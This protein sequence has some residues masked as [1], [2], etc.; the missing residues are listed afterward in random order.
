MRKKIV[1]YYNENPLK[2]ILLIAFIVRL[3][4]VLFS[5]GFGMHDDHFLI[6]ES[7]R[8][9]LEGGD[10]NRWLPW[11]QNTDNP[12]P[13]G[14]SLFYPG[15]MYCFLSILKLI[16]I[17]SLNAQMYF[18]R[19]IH[20]LWSLL[21]VYY[22]YKITEKYTN[23][24]TANI[25]GWALALYFF[26]PWLSVR[27]LVEVVA[28]P[29]LMAA[30]WLY[31]KDET[32]K[33]G[34]VLWVGA[35]MGMAMCVRYQVMFFIG[36]FGLALLIMKRWK[37]AIIY[38]IGVVLS[39]SIIQCIP[40][41][42]LW[43][44]PFAEFWEYISYNWINSTS[45]FNQPWYNYILVILGLMLPPISVFIFGGFFYEW[46][47]WVL[48]LPSFA[49]LFFHSVFPN[50]QERF[51]L[52]IF[53]FIIFLG[54]IGIYDYWQ[55][56]KCRFD[57]PEGVETR[58]KR[59]HS[60]Q[61]NKSPLR[62]TFRVCL[63]ISLI[64]NIIALIPTTIHY[65]KKARVEAMVYLSNYPES[66]YYIIEGMLSYGVRMPVEAY[67]DH[68]FKAHAEVCKGQEWN[69]AEQFISSN[70]ISF[71]MFE[72]EENLDARLD[73]AKKYIPNLVYETKCEESFL[74]ALVQAINPINENYPIIIYRNTDVIPEKKTK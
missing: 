73:E 27:N 23:R 42:I 20:A 32:P 15:L 50:K 71:V 49:F 26:M 55:K 56:Y 72:G 2:C 14:H 3:V 8:S 10:Y 12:V 59:E 47:K 18:I 69:T 33:W 13:T 37:D 38:A 41:M 5:K 46:K 35:L 11:S 52:T 67:A 36:G 45:Y 28:I 58:A 17:E 68:S 44:R 9:W 51:I 1:D 54:I 74:D 7:S 16:G 53:P 65:S 34:R 29:F 31:V 70:P 61:A 21:V 19:L 57:R 48:F 43:H 4:A 62:K 6:V 30:T 66:E 22:G 63:W 40:D 39:F 64:L 60:P 24:R 25:A